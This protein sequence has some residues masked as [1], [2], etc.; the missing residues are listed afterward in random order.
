MRMKMTR[1]YVEDYTK[2]TGFEPVQIDGIPEGFSFKSPD[3]E[4]GGKTVKGKYI[5]FIPMK[6]SEQEHHKV[7]GST[8]EELL[9]VYKSIK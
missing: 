3:L 2:N 9:E 7:F 4:I 1:A 8:K 5:A 6:D